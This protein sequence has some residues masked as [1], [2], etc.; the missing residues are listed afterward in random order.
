MRRF[1]QA[2][3]HTRLLSPARTHHE[4]TSRTRV[5]SRGATGRNFRVRCGYGRVTLWPKSQGHGMKAAPIRLATKRFHHINRYKYGTAVV[6][7]LEDTRTQVELWYDVPRIEYLVKVYFWAQ[8]LHPGWFVDRNSTQTP[9]APQSQG[10][11]TTKN[12]GML[13]WGTHVLAQVQDSSLYAV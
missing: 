9:N 12:Y 13:R 10:A 2:E 5:V 8:H 3:A 7:S 11:K 6:V 1:R 4:S